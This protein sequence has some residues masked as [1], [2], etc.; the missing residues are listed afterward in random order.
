MLAN[1][2]WPLPRFSHRFAGRD[3]RHTAYFQSRR[4]S[5]SRSRGRG[6]GRRCRM[7]V[8]VLHTNQILRQALR[9]SIPWSLDGVGMYVES[10]S[11]STLTWS[12]TVSTPSSS[13][14]DCSR[15][16]L[17]FFPF[18]LLVLV[19]VSSWVGRLLAHPPPS[20]PPYGC[21]TVEYPPLTLTS[22]PL[23]SPHL[24]LFAD[25]FRF[26][27]SLYPEPHPCRF[28]SHLS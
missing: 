4:Q 5:P 9:S 21:A 1:T 14:L 17:F 3:K 22:P 2:I 15:A 7:R 25:S 8:L 23:T 19:W 12:P 27:M 24:T 13:N 20:L 18:L 26:A 28:S 11:T 6:R 10:T 16:S